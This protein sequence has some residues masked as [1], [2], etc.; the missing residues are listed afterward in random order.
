MKRRAMLLLALTLLGAA[1][2]LAESVFDGS[3]AAP[4]PFAPPPGAGAPALSTGMAG[5]AAREATAA[6]APAQPD[7][8]VALRSFLVPGLAQQRLGRTTRARVYYGLE[9]LTWIAAG[10]FLYA[11]HSRE[12]SY[13]DYA[14]VF[15]GVEGTDRSDDYW[16]HIGEYLS[17]DG[18]GGYNETVRRDAR[19]LYYPDVAAM[20]TYYR[21]NAYEGADAWSWRSSAEFYRYG[22]LRDDSRFAYRY[23]IYSVFFA[24]ALRVVSVADAVRIVRLESRRAPETGEGTSL[25]IEPTPG[26]AALCV[27]RSF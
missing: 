12:R 8:G 23:A 17:N 21:A 16:E 24:A 6:N 18:V 14:V 7:M 10:S 13:K 25:G 9:T 11:G 3:S 26:G 1:P 4:P 2:A 27:R 19:D 20:N 5:E 22:K 15:A